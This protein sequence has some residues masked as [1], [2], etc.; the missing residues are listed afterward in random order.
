MVKRRPD[1]KLTG[2]TREPGEII[3]EL[4]FIRFVISS[5]LVVPLH[6]QDMMGRGAER[7]P[8]CD[9]TAAR[10]PRSWPRPY[11]IIAQERGFRQALL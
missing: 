2:P 3:L 5:V 4:S 6:V 7:G 10:K 9:N 11:I 8:S 1:G